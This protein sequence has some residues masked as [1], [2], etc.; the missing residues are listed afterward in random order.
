MG[1][2]VDLKD[3]LRRTPLHLEVE[4]DHIDVAQFLLINGA[5]PNNKDYEGY[6]PLHNAAKTHSLDICQLLVS[7]QAKV[8]AE[9]HNW[10][11]PLHLSIHA[12]QKNVTEFLLENGASPNSKS[13][14]V[15]WR[16]SHIRETPLWLA[17][18]MKRLDFC[19]LL[20]SYGAE[21]D[22]EIEN[23]LREQILLSIRNGSGENLAQ[24]LSIWTSSGHHQISNAPK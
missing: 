19:D 9:D 7:K 12:G 5:N 22:N 2:V 1:A 20:V 10:R 23:M 24:S 11:T 17:V 8:F 21:L 15:R 16:S 18:R 3:R 4:T 6:T 14:F 13:N